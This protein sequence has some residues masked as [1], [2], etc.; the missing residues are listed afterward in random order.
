MELHFE[1]SIYQAK[2]VCGFFKSVLVIFDVLVYENKLQ[3]HSEIPSKH[4]YCLTSLR[5]SFTNTS[6]LCAQHKYVHRKYFPSRTDGVYTWWKQNSTCLRGN[7]RQVSLQ[8]VLL[9]IPV[10]NPWFLQRYVP[11]WET[12]ERSC[13]KFFST[14][15]PAVVQLICFT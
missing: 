11:P 1:T 12:A 13:W 10:K 8:L 4:T 9:N 5:Y 2:Q 6:Y 14:I 15:T 7:T 3:Q